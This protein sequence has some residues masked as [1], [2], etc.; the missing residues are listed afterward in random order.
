MP[1][2]HRKESASLVAAPGERPSL[3]LAPLNQK[4]D[5][6][7]F[8]LA[9]QLSLAF[10]FLRMVRSFVWVS[11]TMRMSFLPYDPQNQSLSLTSGPPRSP[12]QSKIWSVWLA[13]FDTAKSGLLFSSSGRFEDCSLWLARKPRAEPWK[14]LVPR[15]VTKLIPM[16]PVAT[17]R[18]P[19]PVV[20]LISSKASKS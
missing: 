6:M 8:W 13:L 15:L 3:T 18:S 16:P 17:L 5:T 20:T 7:S 2:F 19:P 4:S 12:P 14:A 1:W 10:Q 9:C 11:R